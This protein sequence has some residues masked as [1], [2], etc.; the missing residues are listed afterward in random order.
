VW[1]AIGFNLGYQAS[2]LPA[3]V[4]LAYA[5]ESNEFNGDRRLQLNIKDLRPAGADPAR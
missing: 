4:D 5:F 3:R 2:G 1:D